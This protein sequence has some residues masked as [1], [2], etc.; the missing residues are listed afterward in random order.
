MPALPARYF[1]FGSEALHSLLAVPVI[2]KVR[3]Q[4][5]ELIRYVGVGLEV[6]PVLASFVVG[7]AFVDVVDR[8]RGIVGKFTQERL[9]P[10]DRGGLPWRCGTFHRYQFR[11]LL[12]PL[13][14]HEL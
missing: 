7:W 14:S 9:N 5:E 12:S 6:V 4:R 10:L 3:N 2:D 1:E 8:L 11:Q 13:R